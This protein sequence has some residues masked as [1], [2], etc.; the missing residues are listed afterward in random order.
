M[1]RFSPRSARAPARGRRGKKHGS[2]GAGEQGSRGA[3]AE[4]AAWVLGRGNEGR[5]RPSG[6]KRE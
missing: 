4:N 6:N 2:Q 3:A 1:V 5:N